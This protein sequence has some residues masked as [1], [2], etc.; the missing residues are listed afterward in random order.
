MVQELV[1]FEQAA[2]R[3]DNIFPVTPLGGTPVK[4]TWAIFGICHY[5][6]QVAQMLAASVRPT[7]IE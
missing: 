4:V 1:L 6:F 7:G 2:Q 3:N 5:V